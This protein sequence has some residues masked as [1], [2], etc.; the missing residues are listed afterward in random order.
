MVGVEWATHG[1]ERIHALWRS[2]LLPTCVV[3]GVF[4]VILMILMGLP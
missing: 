4:S 3:G 1:T 2:A